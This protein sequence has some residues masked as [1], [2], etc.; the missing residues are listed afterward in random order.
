M[1]RPVVGRDCMRAEDAAWRAEE[2][3]RTGGGVDGR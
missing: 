2:G 1:P 3:G